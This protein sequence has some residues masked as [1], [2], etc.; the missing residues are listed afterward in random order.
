MAGE[1]GRAAFIV[2]NTEIASPPLVPE[3]MLHLAGEITPLW[4]AGE[5][6]L[7]RTGLPPPYWAFAWPGSQALAR[8]VL[9]RPGLVRGRRVM[10]FAAGSGLAAIA[11]VMAGAS[12]TAAVDIDPFAATAQRLNAKLNGVAIDCRTGDATDGP[13]PGCDVVLAGDI[14]YEQPTAAV[15]LAWLRGLAGLGA[16]VLVADPG[17][18][19]APRQGLERVAVFDVPTTRELEDRDLRVTTVWRLQPPSA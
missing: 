19:Y 16:L 4:Q 1:E 5:D 10:D 18:A 14:C 11:A 13:A 12:A 2:R 15:V 7:Q 17:R 9:D 8:L 6:F 3:A